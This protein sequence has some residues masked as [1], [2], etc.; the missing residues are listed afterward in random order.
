MKPDV[1][2]EGLEYFGHHPIALP[3]GVAHKPTWEVER[4][5]TSTR[6]PMLRVRRCRECG[7]TEWRPELEGCG[8]RLLW[9]AFDELNANPETGE[10]DG[11][12]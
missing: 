4:C 5:F 9:P 8:W 7:H 2:T 11:G 12:T 10:D 6:G 3:D 1:Q